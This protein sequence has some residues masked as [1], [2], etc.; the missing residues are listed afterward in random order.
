MTPSQEKYKQRRLAFAEFI[1]LYPFT[2]DDLD[3]EEWRPIE[4]YEGYQIS[5][6]GRVKSFKCNEPQILK[7]MLNEDNYL[8]IYLRSASKYHFKKIHRLGTQSN[9]FSLIIINSECIGFIERVFHGL[10]AQ[11]QHCQF[12]TRRSIASALR[13][14]ENVSL[15]FDC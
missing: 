4:G 5:N 10:F 14:A 9:L 7:P 11:I 6:F 15:T 8:S 12:S 2:T 3:G 1:K 13:N